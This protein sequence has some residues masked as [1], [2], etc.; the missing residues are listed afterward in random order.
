MIARIGG[1]PAFDLAKRFV[2]SFVRSMKKQLATGV[3]VKLLSPSLSLSLFLFRQV[4]PFSVSPCYANV[5]VASRRGKLLLR[6]LHRQMP[7]KIGLPIA[8]L[9][10]E[11]AWKFRSPL[12]ERYKVVGQSMWNTRVTDLADLFSIFFLSFCLFFSPSTCSA[13]LFHRNEAWN[14]CLVPPAS[15]CDGKIWIIQWQSAIVHVC[16][17]L[18]MCSHDRKIRW[19]LEWHWKYKKF[20]QIAR[21]LIV[22]LWQFVFSWMRLNKLSITCP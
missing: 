10:P 17:K 2:R 6:T 16:Y 15:R 14:V 19:G 21:S 7:G 8:G 11:A 3:I 1:W 13:V 4:S 18:L 9:R 22:C 20:R 12:G 5:G